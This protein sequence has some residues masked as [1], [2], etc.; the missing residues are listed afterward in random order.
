MT[1]L[2]NICCDLLCCFV[3]CSGEIVT[4]ESSFKVLPKHVE[5]SLKKA[6]NTRWNT[7]SAPPLRC[8]LPQ[9]STAGSREEGE[10]PKS[11]SDILR[12]STTGPREEGE[13]PKPTND[14]SDSVAAHEEEKEM[15]GSNLKATELTNRLS[16]SEEELAGSNW[17]D[18]DAGLPKDT[19]T[20]FTNNLIPTSSASATATPPSLRIITST[21]DL[22]AGVAPPTVASHAHLIRSMSSS[23]SG[24]SSNTS[25]A[26]DNERRGLEPSTLTSTLTSSRLQNNSNVDTGRCSNLTTTT[27]P[28]PSSS[29]SGANEVGANHRDHPSTDEAATLDHAHLLSLPAKPSFTGLLNIGNSCYMNSVVQCLSNTGSLRDYFISRHFSSDI[30]K[31]NPLGFKGQLATCFFEAIQNLWSGELE[32]FSLKRLKAVVSSRSQHFAGYQQHDSHEFMS[33]LLDGLHEDLNRVQDKPVTA[34]LETSG[35]PDAT[36]AEKAWQVHQLRNDS[37]FVDNFQGQF[38][39]TL[40]C[41]VCQKVIFTPT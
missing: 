17:N 19:R 28:S 1:P 36:L 10:G 18:I 30:N 39:S 38:K 29:S 13:G 3:C 20:V 23:T 27:S 11:A 9:H 26:S 5:V 22:D 7:L 37:Y 40:V 25:D 4:G 14:L 12:H 16:R 32:Y 34:P 2:G 15:P 6:S 33:Y 24:Y 31:R 41:P 35:F 21:N 8:H